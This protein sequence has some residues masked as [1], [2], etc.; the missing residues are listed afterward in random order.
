M[1][2]EEVKV[3]LREVRRTVK[4][5]YD[6][7]KWHFITV[8]AVDLG[9]K[10][11]LKWFFTPYGEEESFKVIVSEAGY[12]DEIPTLT[13]L[14]PSAWI[15]EWELADLFGLKVEG[16]KTGLFLEPDSPKAPLRRG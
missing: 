7:E 4:E 15:S 13:Y 10:V 16:A 5:F 9:G 12:E 2:V 6:P 3:P 11:E 8:N 1:K 14:V